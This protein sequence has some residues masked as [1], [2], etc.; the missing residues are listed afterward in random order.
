MGPWVPKAPGLQRSHWALCLW[1]KEW[2]LDP[3]PA[4]S[5]L[6]FSWFWV[7]LAAHTSMAKR[8]V[9]DPFSGPVVQL[10]GS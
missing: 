2:G 8:G 6:G 10:A 7:G 3:N 9:E 1:A 5:H 4:L